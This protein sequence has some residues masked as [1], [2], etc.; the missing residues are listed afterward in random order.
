MRRLALALVL[1]GLGGLTLL[2]GGV[3]LRGWVGDGIDLVLPGA[4]NVQMNGRGT[5]HLSVTYDLPENTRLNS[6]SQHLERHGWRRLTTEN[7]DR[8]GPAFVRVTRITGLG[9]LREVV[10]VQARPA[11]RQTAEISLARCLQI[12][13]WVT[14]L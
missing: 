6:V 8:P 1:A 13:K 9:T 10:V 4:T 14:C 3:L 12:A 2:C 5:A 7:Y 11:R